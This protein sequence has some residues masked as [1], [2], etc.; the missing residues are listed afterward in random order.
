MTQNKNGLK[1]WKKVIKSPSACSVCLKIFLGQAQGYTRLYSTTQK[2]C[3]VPHMPSA[4][5]VLFSQENMAHVVFCNYYTP[6]SN[7]KKK[8][9]NLVL[10]CS[11]C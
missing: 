8:V 2:S 10:F 11:E 5:K 4:S 6:K 1:H 9:Y 7:A 3:R